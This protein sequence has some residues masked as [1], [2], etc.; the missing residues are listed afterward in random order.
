MA[1]MFLGVNLSVIL[2]VRTW[3]VFHALKLQM[4]IEM[5]VLPMD[6]SFGGRWERAVEHRDRL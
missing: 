3:A 4:V 2:G 1:L 5:H 6:A